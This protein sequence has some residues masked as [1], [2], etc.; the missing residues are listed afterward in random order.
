M[1]GQFELFTKLCQNRN[2]I[3]SKAFEEIFP[4]NLLLFYLSNKCI[5]LETKSYFLRLINNIY[6]DR[7]PRQIIQKPFLIKV[8]EVG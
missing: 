5:S 2:Y 7:E 4:I 6:I 8:V 3:C 1:H